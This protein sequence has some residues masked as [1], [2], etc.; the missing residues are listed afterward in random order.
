MKT[1]VDYTMSDRYATG[2]NCMT[3]FL[4]AEREGFPLAQPRNHLKNNNLPV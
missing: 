1:I 3:P 4:M 2:E